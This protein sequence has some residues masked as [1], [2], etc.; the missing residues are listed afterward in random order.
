MSFFKDFF[1]LLSQCIFSFS[2]FIFIFH[3]HS[4]IEFCEQIFLILFFHVIRLSCCHLIVSFHFLIFSFYI[5][6][7]L[8]FSFYHFPPYAPHFFISP[9]IL[10]APHFLS[11][12]FFPS[13]ISYN[14]HT[15]AKGEYNSVISFSPFL[16]L[17][18]HTTLN[19]IPSHPLISSLSH[20]PLPSHTSKTPFSHFPNSLLITQLSTVSHSIFSSPHSLIITQPS[21]SPPK[22]C[23]GNISL[24]I[25]GKKVSML[26][27][28][29]KISKAQATMTFNYHVYRCDS[30]VFVCHKFNPGCYVIVVFCCC[31]C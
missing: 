3:F 20:V 5:K 6:R 1:L 11:F 31:W 13:L 7:H 18:H 23:A 10:D 22:P 14:P 27:S 2:H 26:I 29:L 21:F 4:L 8:I 9:F 24:N 17:R 15:P 25:Q 16:T 12:H 28:M 30:L 19:G